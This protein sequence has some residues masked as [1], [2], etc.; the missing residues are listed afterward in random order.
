MESDIDTEQRLRENYFNPATG[1]QSA[2][3]LYNK[4]LEE[5]FDVSRK[6]VKE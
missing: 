4:A 5:G 3:R 2:E 1:C 6:S